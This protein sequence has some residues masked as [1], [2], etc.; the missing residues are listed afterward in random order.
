MLKAL[1]VVEIIKLRIFK[2]FTLKKKQISVFKGKK[3][4]YFLIFALKVKVISPPGGKIKF[5]SVLFDLKKT[6]KYQHSLDMKKIFLAQQD[7][8]I[9]VYK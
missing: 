1:K 9:Y 3:T 6:K 8:F 2:Q 5:L 4:S 7:I